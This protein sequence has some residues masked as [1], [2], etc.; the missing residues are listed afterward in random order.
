[1]WESPD[2]W[3]SSHRGDGSVG[4]Q[5]A[6]RRMVKLH[7]D[8]LFMSY[9]LWGKLF[10]K[11]RSLINV[12]KWRDAALSFFHFDQLN[13]AV[14][15]SSCW[16]LNL[17]ES[18]VITVSTACFRGLFFSLWVRPRISMFGSFASALWNPIPKKRNI[19]FPKTLQHGLD[20][21]DRKTGSREDAL[22]NATASV[23]F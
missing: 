6:I 14:S 17:W 7:P 12:A 4:L 3:T 11:R 21:S 2:K 22:A 5:S 15:S 19:L 1:M 23:V 18:D 20:R 16:L 9:N 13:A 10:E 8:H